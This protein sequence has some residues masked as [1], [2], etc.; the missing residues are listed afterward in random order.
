MKALDILS[1]L[2][3]PQQL[4]VQNTEGPVLILAGAGSGKTKALTHRFAYLLKEKQIS[5]DEILCVT[6]TNKA[7]GEMRD[8][9]VSLLEWENKG[10]RFDWRF[11]WLG[12]FHS[13][14]VRILRQ[15][16]DQTDNKIELNFNHAFSIFDESDSLTAVK[17][18]LA[19]L[20]LDSKQYNPGVVRHQISGAKNE[21]LDPDQYAVY[22]AG[23]W[24]QNV[25]AVY[26]RYQNLLEEANALDFDD[27]LNKTIKL[28]QNNPDIRLK[29]QEKF[30]YVM[31]DEYQDTNQ[32]QYLL[33][34]ML[35]ALNKNLFVIG[36]D[37]QS[38]YS[39]RGADFRNILN[40]EKD[41]PDAK[42]IKLE[43]N[44]RSTQN[45]LDAA[46]AIINLNER[47]SDK[48]L[49]SERTTGSL[50][51]IVQCRD[52]REEAEFVAREIK[53]LLAGGI[54]NG[55][56]SFSDFVVLYRTNAQSRAL[57]EQLM[58]YSMPY[59]I[60]GGV[61]FYERK[62]IKDLL[63]Y[64]RLCLNPDDWL[65][66]ERVV[67]LPARGIG[68]KALNEYLIWRSDS[69]NRSLPTKVKAFLELVETIRQEA[70]GKS[71]SEY[72]EKILS[73]VKYKAY[74]LDGSLEGETRWEN[75]QE[76]LGV[77]EKVTDPLE[78]LEQVSLVQDT[79][80]D[81]QFLPGGRDIQNLGSINLMTMHAA[82]GLEFSVVFL[83]GMEEGIFPHSRA[84]SEQSEMEEERRLAYVAMTRAKDRLYLLHAGERMLYGSKQ[85]NQPSRFIAEIPQD[86]REYI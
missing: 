83:V 55:A 59:R 78:F 82:K 25:V 30:R 62:E 72:L 42:V 36:D 2:N 28:L 81:K 46:Q 84:L 64:L 63:S 48:Q 80:D 33:I 6:F 12:T 73:M 44:Y 17:H 11:P 60:V 50:V 65:S 45:I 51:S 15:E 10:G 68:P 23:I 76:F 18:S 74:L 41:Y 5:S 43:Q 14:G 20:G 57:E 53:G 71:T 49:W 3:E 32:A 29:Y 21:L 22:A 27:I 86:L 77:A 35:S 75:V 47:R 69:K 26:R 85:I 58:R 16:I 4:A 79:E 56:K 1:S 19:D 40:F 52:E 67:N 31:V 7:A 8:R 9:I 37:W 66:F 70:N 38:V 54:F 24:Q 34:K 39:W 13:I 61:K